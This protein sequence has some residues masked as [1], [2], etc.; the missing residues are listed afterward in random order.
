MEDGNGWD[1]DDIELD[2]DVE[3]VEPPTASNRYLFN[4][5]TSHTGYEHGENI[6]QSR[7]DEAPRDDAA[8]DEADDDVAA[9][10]SDG[11]RVCRDVFLLEK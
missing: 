10:S 11:L 9:D 4:K 8:S 3:V 6:L 2:D 1:F 5:E 7:S